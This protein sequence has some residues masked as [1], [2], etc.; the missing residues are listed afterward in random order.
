[1]STTINSILFTYLVSIA[2]SF[3]LINPISVTHRKNNQFSSRELFSKD[4]NN[5]AED[6]QNEDLQ[7]MT[8]LDWIDMDSFRESLSPSDLCPEYPSTCNPRLAKDVEY[9]SA[10]LDAWE[11]DIVAYKNLP[12]ASNKTVGARIE[13]KRK[14]DDTNLSGYLV[15]RSTLIYDSEKIQNG[16]T[17]SLPAIILFH[18]GAGPQDIFLRW[19]A[20]MIV[21][22][23]IWGDDGCLVFIADIVSDSTGSTWTDRDK[24]DTTRKSLLQYTKREEDGVMRRW[25]LRQT[26]G[27]ILDTLKLFDHVDNNKIAAMGWCMGGHPILELSTMEVDGVKALITFH[28]VFDGIHENDGNDDPIKDDNKSILICN[29]LSDPFVPTESLQFGKTVFE[30][31]NWDV[32]V[33]NFDNVKHGFTNPA[34]DFNPSENFA[35]DKHAADCSW[36]ATRRLL[37]RQLLSNN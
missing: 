28:G 35:F 36:E 1:M 25:Q 23:N 8:T 7:I 10:V 19:K 34:Q 11:V 26:I 2:V 15:A 31:N 13:Y 9:A 33:L 22:D 6:I 37:K 21:R 16:S 14:S 24:Y 30:Q 12:T 20:D 32:E 17:K 5:M 3:N 29:G 4:C 27:A 18:T